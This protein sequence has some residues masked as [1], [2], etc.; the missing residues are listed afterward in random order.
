MM[1]E[2]LAVAVGG[3]LGA[4]ARWQLAG[5][6]Q[7]ALGGAFPWGTLVVNALGSFL[8]GFLF[9]WLL[10]RSASESLRLLLTVGF[11]GAFTTFSTFSL[12]TV[13]LFEE[14]AWGWALGNAA[15]QLLLGIPLAW[16]GAQLARAL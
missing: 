2:W 10:E 5:I 7:R 16:L 6:V 13:R 14:Q 1:H 8:L 9:V 15:A 11:L 4:L 3:A 12:E